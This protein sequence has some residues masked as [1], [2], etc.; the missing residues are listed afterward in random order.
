MSADGGSIT[1]NT[2]AFEP[3]FL[4]LQHLVL[5]NVA[6]T[7]AEF[8]AFTRSFPNI[9]RLTFEPG[10]NA[11]H[12]LH[13]VDRILGIIIANVA[14]GGLMWSK[15]ASIALGTSREYFSVAELGST[16]ATIL[17]LQAAGHPI[18]RLLLPEKAHAA[19]V[20]MGELIEIEEYDVDW[21]RTF[22][23]WG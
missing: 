3:N 13:S 8:A 6:R 10:E 5:T 4:T 9:G 11:P 22:E 1:L 20:E 17:Q 21:P 19:M 12:S 14:N 7:V 2:H 15:L 23:W 16:K 18:R